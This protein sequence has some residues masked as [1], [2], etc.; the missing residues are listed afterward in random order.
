MKKTS[1]LF[2]IISLF[3]FTVPFSFAADSTDVCGITLS[4][5]ESG[6]G[7]VVMCGVAYGCGGVSDGVC[8]ERYSSGGT[9]LEEN[10]THLRLRLDTTVL[11]SF[12][13]DPVIHD[14]GD[15]A[16]A[17]IA[18]DCTEIQEYSSGS[19]STIGLDCDHDMTST[20]G[21]YRA[22]CDNVPKTAS[23][24]NCPDPDCTTELRF[25]A[26]DSDSDAS[27]E[28]VQINLNDLPDQE[29]T[30]LQ[31]TTGPD[32]NIT[33][34]GYTGIFNYTCSLPGYE[35]YENSSYMQHEANALLCPMQCAEQVSVSDVEDWY[36]GEAEDQGKSDVSCLVKSRENTA[37]CAQECVS[38][39]CDSIPD[40]CI[41]E[42]PG[43]RIFTGVVD[44]NLTYD[45]CCTGSDEIPG[46]VFEVNPRNEDVENLITRSYRKQ[47]DDMPV[48][49]KILAYEKER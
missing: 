8:P 43:T 11:T 46:N 9:E 37:V 18:G 13:G 29:S 24:Y 6:Y 48:T 15:A 16:C 7:G 10:K 41:G 28:D 3:L 32:G 4:L 36:D 12:S 39:D 17:T 22:V 49:L 47:I 40:H 23:C 35:I 45:V 2:M 30:R 19:W 1:V 33:L 21:E 42:E 20:N 26:Y 5:N 25:Y 34:T 38:G 27:L 14:D 31:E 44:G